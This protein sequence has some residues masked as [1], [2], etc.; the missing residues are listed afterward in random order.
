MNE[1][2]MNVKQ[3]KFENLLAQS[4]LEFEKIFKEL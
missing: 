2:V 3:T 4:N 1:M